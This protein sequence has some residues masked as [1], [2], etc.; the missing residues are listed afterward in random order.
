MF[1]LQ[2]EIILL[3]EDNITMLRR[4]TTCLIIM[5]LSFLATSLLFSSVN[6]K[7]PM[8]KAT[9][10]KKPVESTPEQLSGDQPTISFDA[11]TFDAGEVWEG[12]TVSH[13]F[14]VKNT[15]TAVLNINNVKPG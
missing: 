11:T 9:V 10:K 2:R 8:I 1:E 3:R 12:D 5:M 15:G 7:E 4:P 6:A 13:S 14:T